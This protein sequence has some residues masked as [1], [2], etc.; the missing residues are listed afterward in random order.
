MFPIY[1]YIKEYKGLKDF[2]I[3]FDNN[4]EIK[5]NREKDT[6][7]INKKY[8][9]ANNDIENF[10]SIGKTKGNID[11]INLLIGKNGSGK[12]NILEVLDSNLILDIE[13]RNNNIIILYKSSINDEDFIIEGNGNRFLEIKKLPIVDELVK[14]NYQDNKNY[15]EKMGVIK[16]SFREKT[17]NAIQREILFE[18]NALSKTIIYKWNIGLGNV[19]KEEIY[20][21]L[22]K[23]N[24]EKNND[25]FENVYFT[26]LIPD[27]YE[28]L[29]K[30]KSG[31]IKEKIKKIENL[32]FNKIDSL[33]KLYNN[34]NENNFNFDE[35][36]NFDNKN[37]DNIKDIIFNNYFNYIYLHIIL[38]ILNKNSKEM[39]ELKEKKDE[40]LELLNDK[41][42]F[43]K[44][45]ILFKK[46]DKL[47]NMGFDWYIPEIYD[48]IKRI[49]SLI[50]KI[51]E[52]E[53]DIHNPERTIKKIKI[54]YKKK[55]KKLVELLK[56]YDSFII[57][58]IE[59]SLDLSLKNIEDIIKIE[60][61]GLSD[62]ER[63]KLQYFSTLHGVLRGELKN[64]EYITLLFDEVETYL[65]PEWSRR[66]LYEL[67]EELGRYEDKK[68][69][70]IFATHSPFLIAD[71]LAKDCIYLS[72]NKKGKIKAEIKE[73]VKTFGANIIDLFK[74]TMF[75]E[76]TFGKFATEKI[77]GLVDKIEKAEKYS[78]IKHEVDFIIDEIGEKLIS[79]KLKSMI[80]SK[81]ENKDEE[82]D[83]EYYRKK[84]EEYQAKLDE[85][86]KKENNRNSKK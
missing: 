39:Y 25:N 15:I 84:I 16:F 63:I 24:Q 17:M 80:E 45:E 57:P 66:F 54:D 36:E 21:Y 32:D 86:E 1:M 41:S 79:N 31:E 18:K 37:E 38:K 44:C 46:Y 2:E 23:A 14:E 8:E 20:N 65:H 48:I 67:I 49:A 71:V 7:T 10:Y 62:G 64:K 74:N 42:L 53:I 56:E 6:L 55:N 13:N 29:K 81:F 30:S 33:F 70:L 60:E 3:T 72:K 28:E 75:L 82:K 35:I 11:S 78:D 52:K 76:S 43:E 12:T 69:K 26:L 68:F 51:P 59:N 85:L 83:E 9:S 40:L 47:I 27:L 4:Y 5:Y 34:K 58:R 73:D 77:K 50:E 61:E 22:I 19:S